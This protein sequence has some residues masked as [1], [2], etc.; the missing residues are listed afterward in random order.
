M[1]QVPRVEVPSHVPPERVVEFDMWANSAEYPAYATPHDYWQSLE[2]RGAP[3][4]CWTPLNGGHWILR[5]FE[6]A[7][8]G[9]RDWKFFTSFPLGIP[10]R[11]GG[12][13]KLVPV[14][15]DPPEHQRYRNLLAP[16]FGPP[17][18]A[19][20]EPRIRELTVGLIEGFLGSGRCEFVAD[21]SMKIPTGIFLE[22]MGMPRDQLPQF[23]AWE[24]AHMRGN[25]AEQI[26]AGNAI[27]GYLAQF[28]ADKERSPGADVSSALLQAQRL[29]EQPWEHE[30]V[31]NC[32]YLLYL[33]G[34]DTVANTMSFMWRRLAADPAAQRHVADNLASIGPIAEELI[35][36]SEPALHTRR[37]RSDGYFRGVFMKAGE[38]ALCVPNQAN[39]DPA[40]H[41]N[42]AAVDWT[43]E[44]SMQ[45]TFGAGPHRC[46]GSH[47]ARLEIRIVLEEWFRRIPAFGIEPG[48]RIDWACA[49]IMTLERLPLVWPAH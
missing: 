19:R 14:E 28:F 15:V 8:E 42:P 13:R 12:A 10:A 1:A 48:A 33:A 26:A 7:R 36:L 18:V 44:N 38:A 29:A 9:F 2:D 39:R 25:Q 24:H 21:M 22:L 41:R 5:G 16:L 37:V 17:A 49:N 47:L 40:V 11:Q 6:D 3:R 4:I 23:L 20:M 34:L 30:D 46:V 32:A 27:F 31:L 43:R 45:L 35:R